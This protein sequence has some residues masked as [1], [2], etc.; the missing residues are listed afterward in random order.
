M[1]LSKEQYRRWKR[2]YSISDLTDNEKEA[3][4]KARRRYENGGNNNDGD[5]RPQKSRSRLE[6]YKEEARAGLKKPLHKRLADKAWG[7]V[8]EPEEKYATRKARE[9]IVKEEYETARFEERKKAAREK[10]KKQAKKGGFLSGLISDIGSLGGNVATNTGMRRGRRS[11]SSGFDNFGGGPSLD[12][13]GVMGGNPNFDF[14]MG[15]KRR[16]K[17]KKNINWF[18]V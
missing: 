11:R 2:N 4:M 5:S 17:K 7:Y 6:Q 18:E 16:K 13:G 14:R 9:R 12:F 3:Y 15:G 8:V 10:A 1:E